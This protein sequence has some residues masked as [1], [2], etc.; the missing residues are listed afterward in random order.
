MKRFIYFSVLF[1][2]LCSGSI[3]LVF[4]YADG[5]TDAFYAK[6]TTPKQKSL[7]VGS[8]RAAQGII[9]SI[10]NDDNK[11]LSLYNYAFSIAH[12]AYGKAYYSSIQ[13]KLDAQSENSIFI[14]C[15]N[16]WTISEMTKFA[17]DSLKFRETNSFMDKTYFVN[18]KPNV[19]YLMESFVSKNIEILTNKDRKG[20]YQTF[21][22]HDDGWLEVTIESD[23]IS[24]KTRTENKIE[25]YLEKE[26]ESAG[27]SNIRVSY[28]KKTIQLFQ[29][30][31]TVL[32]VRIPVHDE[33]LAIENR[34]MPKFDAIIQGIADDY[35]IPY[36][37]AMEYRDQYQYTDGNHLTIASAK[38]FSLYL[39]DQI[40][41][42]N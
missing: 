31:G 41:T 42:N 6:F 39:A 12:S 1:L 7:I 15:V 8:S 27:L 18:M 38:R 25:T 37:N 2:L 21:F 11:N 5:S 40:N 9:P 23:M 10:M 3:Y 19:E 13:K 17:S 34:L 32:L 30:H 14:V 20:D 29:N 35:E 26:K 22:V 16:P 36:I 24:T 28:L 4:S 33:M